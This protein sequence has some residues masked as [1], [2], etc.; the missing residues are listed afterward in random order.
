MRIAEAIR[1]KVVEIDR[2]YRMSWDV[3]AIAHVVKI[4]PTSVAKILREVRGPRP[5]KAKRPHNRRTAFLR[6]DVM[7]SSDFK[8]LPGGRKLLKTLDEMSRYKLGWEVLKTESAEA[9][10]RHAEDVIGRMGRAPLVWKFD[11]GGPFKS[12][13]FRDFLA[14]HGIIAYPIPQRAPWVNGRC[15]R[16]NQEQDNWLLPL[17]GKDLPDVELDREVDEGMLMLN[18][19]KPRA[20]LAFRRSAEVYFNTSGVEGLDREW[21]KLNLEDIVC[22]LG[23]TGNPNARIH[24][25]AVRKLLEKWKLYEEWEEIPRGTESVNRTDDLNVAF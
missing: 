6:R 25:R 20:V 1:K 16:D 17:A 3:R 15:E 13:K 14:R 24:R 4:S 5:K 22:Q 18:Y 12:K 19:V 8:S 9:L 2:R 7:W 10:V 23:S 21:L 11:N